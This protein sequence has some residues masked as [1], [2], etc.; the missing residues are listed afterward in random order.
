[1]RT[2]L[3]IEDDVLA[4]ARALADA[5][6]Y[7]L[8]GAVTELARRGLR[9]AATSSEHGLPTFAV[10]ADARPLIPESVADGLDEW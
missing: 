1:M 7:S 8:G 3:T 2:T 6:G 5:K 10:A 4:A 9:R